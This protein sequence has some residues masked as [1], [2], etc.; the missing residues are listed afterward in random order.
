MTLIPQLIRAIEDATADLPDEPLQMARAIACQEVGVV[1]LRRS[2]GHYEVIGISGGWAQDPWHHPAR[3][4][5]DLKRDA[6]RYADADAV[7]VILPN[8]Q[9]LLLDPATRRLVKFVTVV[10]GSFR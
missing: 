1:P 4:A 9:R 7:G 10:D 3:N 6:S 8:G 5:K 2:R